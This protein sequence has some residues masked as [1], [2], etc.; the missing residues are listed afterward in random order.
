MRPEDPRSRPRQGCRRARSSI[1]RDPSF[2]THL[3]LCS[4]G[5]TPLHRSYEEIRLLGG[6]RLVVVASFRPTALTDPSRPPRVRT[7]DVP[8]PPLPLP[9]QPRL[10]FGRRVRRHAHP[11]GMACPGVHL[12]SVLRFASGFF[13]TRPRGASI[14]RLTTDHAAC[15]CLRLTV[16]TNSLR[17][18][19]A[20]PIQC[21]CR[22]HLPALRCAARLQAW[23]CRPTT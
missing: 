11:A 4:A 23:R 17:R 16:A 10:D 6:R 18:G 7:L 3:S 1:D 13:P 9:P 2:S 5:I 14:A 19:L 12:R 20:P 15:S 8:P 21:P 22:A